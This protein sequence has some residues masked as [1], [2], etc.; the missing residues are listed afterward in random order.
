MLSKSWWA[1]SIIDNP[2]K[3][4]FEA[5]IYIFWFSTEETP[6]NSKWTNTFL[7]EKKFANAFKFHHVNYFAI[8]TVKIIT[9]NSL[10][11]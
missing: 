6:E 4:T 10:S 8:V 1:K 2:L 9:L 5:Y 3:I 11:D 7:K